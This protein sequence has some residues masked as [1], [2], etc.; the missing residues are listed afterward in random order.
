MGAQVGLQ[1]VSAVVV[2]VEGKNVSTDKRI[3]DQLVAP[4]VPGV[5]FVAGG[6]CENLF[7]TGTR[8]NSLLEEACSNGDFF[9][10][11][12]R[13]YRSDQEVEELVRRY[14]GRIFVWGVHE[15]ENLF[16][17]PNIVWQTLQFLGH[18]DDTHSVEAVGEAIERVAVDLADWIAADWVASELDRAFQPPSRRIASADPKRSLE[19]YGVS[20]QEKLSAATS[21]TGLAERYEEKH[22]SINQI[23][24]QQQWLK[25]LPGKQ[26]LRRYLMAYPTVRSDDFVRAAAS[27]V[28][29]R[30]IEVAELTRLRETLQNLPT[31]T[32]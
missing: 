19:Q 12:D 32:K 30:G 24:T 17:E 18:I 27:L 8:A 14:R 9:A 29:E 10:I 16:L 15:I 31:M 25:R 4:M 20:L 13:D 2:F 21:S 28:R 6:S 1:L 26:I 11:V 7:A 5:N 3:L 23:L 22:A